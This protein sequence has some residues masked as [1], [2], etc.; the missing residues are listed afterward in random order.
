MSM[1]GA[2]PM[3]EHH[4][5]HHRGDCGKGRGPRERAWHGGPPGPPRGPGRRRRGDVRLAVLACLGEKP[6]HGYEV[7]RALEERSGG[8]WRPS[9]GSIYPTLQ[10]LADE[11]L[12]VG[13]DDDAGRRVYSLTDAG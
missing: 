5:H 8:R 7:I 6:M 9:A 11:G 2:R 10:L 1:K 4:H 13:Q 12:V 3:R